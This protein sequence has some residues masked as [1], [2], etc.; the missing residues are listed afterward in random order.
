MIFIMLIKYYLKSLTRKAYWLYRLS[1]SDLGKN[2]SISFPFKLEGKGQL[3]IGDD[4]QLGKNV[5]F[6]IAQGASLNFNNSCFIQ[7]NASIILANNTKAVIENNFSLGESSKL[8]INA[9]WEIKGHVTI[10]SNCSISARE[11]LGNGSFY[12][13]KNSNIG[14]N[15]IIDLV[16]N[17]IIED[18]VAI[19]PNC[20]LYT[21]DHDYSDKSLASWKG[22]IHKDK[23]LIRKGA[24]VGSNVT[25]L[26]GII[27]GER[28]VIAAGSVLTRSVPS[29]CI[30][31]G[32]P[33]K[34]IKEIK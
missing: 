5:N 20:T 23:I 12:I 6:G 17:V 27:I 14:D 13:G 10:A 29:N 32:V 33:A 9:L 3:K 15:T 2:V 4:C 11:S 18:D 26:P 16:D 22:K 19:G 8:Y 30:Y 28:A 1:K 7:K 31:G 21:H 25:I 34:F 24:W